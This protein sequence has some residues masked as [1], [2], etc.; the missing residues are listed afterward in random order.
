[1]Y[2]GQGNPDSTFFQAFLSNSH[3]YGGIEL[4]ILPLRRPSGGEYRLLL[5]VLTK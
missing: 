2:V 3:W 5:P 4:E 1:M